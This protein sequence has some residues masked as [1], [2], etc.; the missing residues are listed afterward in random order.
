VSR[1]TQA[2][3][4]H[5]GR[6]V[7]AGIR[8]EDLQRAPSSS[9]EDIVI[10]A[11]VDL[12]ESVGN[13][14]FLHTRSGSWPLVARGSPHDLPAIGAPVTFHVAPEKIHFFDAESGG[15]I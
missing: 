15:R 11:V 8:P 7:V 10:A 12:I 1:H 9:G 3:R 5:V 6:E 2:L 4:T 14:S 13:E